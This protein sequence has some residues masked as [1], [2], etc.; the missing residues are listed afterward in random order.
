MIARAL[1]V[2]VFALLAVPVMSEAQT[3]EPRAS[4][5]VQGPRADLE[6][7]ASPFDSAAVIIGGRPVKVCYSRPRK[8]G[9]PIMGRL[10][11][12]GAP[13]RI[14][15]DE[16]T[17]I[18]LPV[19]ATIAGVA[20]DAGSYSVYAIPSANEWEIVVNR[21]AH[22]WGVP[23]DSAV[24][25]L[26]VGSGRVPVESAAHVED[27]LHMELVARNADSAELVVHWDRTIVRIP[28][29]LFERR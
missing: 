14:G 5:W 11:P 26:D 21:T 17:A 19:R 2:L 18:Y 12:F 16:A 10:V 24:R 6:L 13:W 8:L 3:S 15:A 28:I 4:C 29:V 1:R 27:L 9:R 22:R 25:R 20:V 7:R 23:I